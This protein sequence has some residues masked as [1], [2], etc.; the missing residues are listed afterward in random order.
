VSEVRECP[1]DRQLCADGE[2]SGGCDVERHRIARAQR[3]LV[4]VGRRWAS[5]R[6][7]TITDEEALILGYLS[8]SRSGGYF[9]RGAWRRGPGQRLEQLGLITAEPAPAGVLARIVE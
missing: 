7:E 1:W 4:V 9:L 5:A 3:R 6:D 8:R 2:C